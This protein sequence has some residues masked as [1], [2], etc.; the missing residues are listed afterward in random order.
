MLLGQMFEICRK[1]VP[2]AVFNHLLQ[3]MRDRDISS[4]QLGLL[5]D[6]LDEAPE[7]LNSE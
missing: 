5:A 6:W 7:V 4:D 2:P 3:R 1:N